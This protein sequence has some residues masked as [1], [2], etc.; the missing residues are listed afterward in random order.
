MKIRSFGSIIGLVGSLVF[1]GAPQSYAGEDK[2]T[3]A[4]ITKRFAGATIYLQRPNGQIQ[5][6]YKANGDLVGAG[7][8]NLTDRGRWWV[9]ENSLCR[10]WNRWRGGKEACFDIVIKGNTTTF[11]EAGTT[12]VAESTTAPK[13]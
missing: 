6:T 9:K 3:G 2:M 8:Y 13:K 7:D 1:F 5:V 4:Q 12:T 10:Q 11:F